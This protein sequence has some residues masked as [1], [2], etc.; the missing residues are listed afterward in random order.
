MRPR[1]CRRWRCDRAAARTPTN[2]CCDCCLRFGGRRWRC[3]TGNL[4][5]TC[6]RAK[7]SGR[8]GRRI[9]PGGARGVS[10]GNRRL[11]LQV[12]PQHAGLVDGLAVHLALVVRAAVEQDPRGVE[13]ICVAH[14]RHCFAGV[15]ARQP[16][17]HVQYASAHPVDRLVTWHQPS[18]CLVHKPEGPEQR[19]LPVRQ[20]LEI[21]AELRFSPL[22]FALE[23]RRRRQ[24][25]VDGL[26]S[27]DTWSQ[28]TVDDPADVLAT[29]PFTDR[30][31]LYATQGA[32]LKAVEVTV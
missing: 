5:E 20:A 14:D 4:R 11:A 19:H 28:C 16:P 12:E 8:G 27:P 17:S 10:P 6:S 7:E 25:L 29:Q 24:P 31:G 21:A 15:L 9:G 18:L 13:G 1:T 22:R 32:E 26:T 23:N 30:R 3:P 2:R